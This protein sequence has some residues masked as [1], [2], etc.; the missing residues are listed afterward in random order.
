MGRSGMQYRTPGRTVTI[1]LFSGH[2][3]MGG[4]G[5]E[6]FHP[7]DELQSP[8]APRVHGGGTGGVSKRRSRIGKPTARKPATS[9]TENTGYILALPPR[10]VSRQHKPPVAVPLIWRHAYPGE[11]APRPTYGP[12]AA[13]H[14]SAQPWPEACPDASGSI[15]VGAVGGGGGGG[16]VFDLL[17]RRSRANSGW[18]KHIVA[19]PSENHR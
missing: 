2:S 1:E 15:A 5:W 3:R 10:T 8:L 4:L 18:R 17:W 19:P 11:P 6:D 14:W 7:E 9:T 12:G 16:S 13:S